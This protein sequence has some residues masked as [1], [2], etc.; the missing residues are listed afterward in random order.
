MSRSLYLACDK[1]HGLVRV[2][3]G[4]YSTRNGVCEHLDA[5]YRH[6]NV[7]SSMTVFKYADGR[8]SIPWSPDVPTPRGAERVEV[9]GSHNVRKLERELDAKDSAR[10]RKHK[11]SVERVFGPELAAR[12]KNLRQ[13]AREHP[14]Q[15]GRDLAAA[16]L[17]RS[18]RG[19]SENYD[20][21]NH[22]SD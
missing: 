7:E 19:Y 1:C 20:P 8:T 18:Q 11:E 17:Q 10:H 6:R 9:R 16:A 15:F 12:R 13:I 21:G 22:R 4:S 3:D 5:D 2:D 14:H